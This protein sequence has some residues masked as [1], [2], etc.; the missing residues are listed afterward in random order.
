MWTRTAET[1]F[2][3]IASRCFVRKPSFFVLGNLVIWNYYCV[4]F[5]GI[6]DFRTLGTPDDTIW[7]GFSQLP[8]YKDK[9]PKWD[10]QD[11]VNVIGDLEVEGQNLLRVSLHP[12]AQI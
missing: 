7:P 5:I 3:E 8:D 2:I 11:I 12:F 10:K 6:T 1:A 9:F 4:S